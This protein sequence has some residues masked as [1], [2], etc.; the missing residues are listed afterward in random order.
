VKDFYEDLDAIYSSLPE[1][2]RERFAEV[3]GVLSTVMA[4][5]RRQILT[6][7]VQLWRCARGYP[8]FK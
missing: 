8:R 2:E 4:A 3:I 6:N 5:E 7:T 1:T